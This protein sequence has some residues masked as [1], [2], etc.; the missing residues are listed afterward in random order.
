MHPSYV[1]DK[2]K[3]ASVFNFQ[4]RAAIA[5]KHMTVKKAAMQRA[6][7][8]RKRQTT[9]DEP[10]V[11]EIDPE[12]AVK[13]VS[14][15]SVARTGNVNCI[16]K[17]LSLELNAGI[18]FP[19]MKE[20]IH[21]IK[22]KDTSAVIKA[23]NSP[24]RRTLLEDS[25][26]S[27][28]RAT[29]HS[30]S[31]S[32]EHDTLRAKKS[33]MSGLHWKSS[34][35]NV[36]SVEKPVFL[37]EMEEQVSPSKNVFQ[38]TL[39]KRENNKTQA[40]QI[41]ADSLIVSASRLCLA[42]HSSS[43]RSSGFWFD[44]TIALA[45]ISQET[46][47]PVLRYFNRSI[48]E[49]I[50]MGHMIAALIKA[51]HDLS[52]LY[53]Q[54]FCSWVE[55][56]QHLFMNARLTTQTDWF[57]NSL[58]SSYNHIEKLCFVANEVIAF[59]EEP[60][61]PAHSKCEQ[62]RQDKRDL[63]NML[64]LSYE[65]DV[66]KSQERGAAVQNYNGEAFESEKLSQ[67]ISF[68]QN[69]SYSVD[70]GEES[71]TE[72]DSDENVADVSFEH[73]E[74]DINVES[75]SG[76]PKVSIVVAA[77]RKYLKLKIELRNNVKDG[78]P[79]Q[80]LQ[81]S[82]D[83][84]KQILPSRVAYLHTCK[85][86][87]VAPLPEIFLSE[88]DDEIE[89]RH[90]MLGVRGCFALAA[91]CCKFSS[92]KRLDLQNC[93]ITVAGC[94]LLSE[95]VVNC[96][97]LMYVNLGSCIPTSESGNCEEL[98]VA[99]ANF[100]ITSKTLTVAEFILSHN[101][102]I[103]IPIIHWDSMHTDV[104]QHLSKLDLSHCML[105]SAACNPL[106]RV[107]QKC[108]KLT[109]LNLQWNKFNGDAICRLL[110][111]LALHKC[112]F[113]LDLSWNSCINNKSSEAIQKLLFKNATLSSLNLS[114]CNIKPMHAIIISAGYMANQTL[115]KFFIEG[116]PIGPQGSFAMLKVASSEYNDEVRMMSLGGCNLDF[117]EIDV[118]LF[119]FSHPS[120]DEK[121]FDL[122]D[123]YEWACVFFLCALRCECAL[124]ICTKASLN[125]GSWVMPGKRCDDNLWSLESDTPS[126]QKEKLICRTKHIT[127]QR[128]C[129]V[130][131]VPKTGIVR[132]SIDY[133]NPPNIM[134]DAV[135]SNNLKLISHTTLEDGALI[136]KKSE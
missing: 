86:F 89:L 62:I 26:K 24:D 9:P 57:N 60:D 100:T 23:R 59:L 41:D 29:G 11:L 73:H 69:D 68:D 15:P 104:N 117:V 30:P 112:L 51:L 118:E 25:S 17:P 4:E 35:G 42:S 109:S 52:D 39:I 81:A 93:M 94:L 126:V 65:F 79:S 2:A 114:S 124:E 5:E 134:S 122:N 19:K 99:I 88:T 82:T 90:Y 32:T 121:N 96:S 87:N 40:L 37:T 110:D 108:A 78:R 44:A 27:M 107:V 36:V 43:H 74:I 119:D 38:N 77:A 70:L 125:G 131:M 10:S 48:A 18:S 67:A 101:S 53:Q 63:E 21:N 8:F 103:G 83:D 61:I 66:T 127:E 71:L 111:I 6:E 132:L 28:S 105:G 13:H 91:G 98:G 102:L 92:L 130:E 34:S 64:T 75:K 1:P 16:V 7:K 97:K 95:A 50:N 120:C 133:S 113:E 129:I 3:K 56:Q 20:P 85:A 33:H 84:K 115:R 72:D 31:Q 135:F 123:E 106:S 80:R 47:Q 49:D 46:L 128:Q 58:K 22:K 76:A 136:S 12:V 54:H 45:G 55:E 116:N 14:L